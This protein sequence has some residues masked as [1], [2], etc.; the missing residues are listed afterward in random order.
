[1][2][3][4][5]RPL[6]ALALFGGAALLAWWLARFIPA[7]RLKQLLYRRE[8]ITDPNSNAFWYLIVAIIVQFA[9]IGWFSS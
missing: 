9:I 4:L 8:E 5:V 3:V 6:A 1:V 7:G 2:E